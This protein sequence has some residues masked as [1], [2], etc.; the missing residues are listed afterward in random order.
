MTCLMTYKRV[1][2]PLV[3]QEQLTFLQ[4]ILAESLPTETVKY[5]C[6]MCVSFVGWR[7]LANE[8]V[9]GRKFTA[10]WFSPWEYSLAEVYSWGVAKFGQGEI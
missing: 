9:V 10:I 4:R 3:Q 2:A 7:V 8:Q 5:L 6:K 1:I